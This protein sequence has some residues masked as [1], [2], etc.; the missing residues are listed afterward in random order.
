MSGVWCPFSNRD[1]SD[2]SSER[3]N[4]YTMVPCGHCGRL[5][6]P[7]ERRGAGGTDARGFHRFSHYLPRHKAATREGTHA[8]LAR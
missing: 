2:Y 4:E 5:V 7:V 6:M 8:W 3:P 1:W